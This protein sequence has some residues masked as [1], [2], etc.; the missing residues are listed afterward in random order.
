[1]ECPGLSRFFA[2]QIDALLPGDKPPRLMV[3]ALQIYVTNSNAKSFKYSVSWIIGIIGSAMQRGR[4]LLVQCHCRIHS[5][6]TVQFLVG[7]NSNSVSA[8]VTVPRD[9]W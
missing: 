9:A 8:S 7:Y 5:S 4:V 1:M 6:S 3:S 2:A